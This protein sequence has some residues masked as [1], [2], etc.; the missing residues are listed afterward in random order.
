[1]HASF[2]GSVPAR[3]DRY[4]GPVLFEPYADDLVGRLEP[5]DD[6]RVLEVACGT[7]IVTRRLRQ[8]LPAGPAPPP[9]A[10]PP[11]HPPGPPP[12]PPGPGPRRGPPL[13]PPHDSGGAP[14]GGGFPPPPPA[15]PPAGGN[16]ARRRRPAVNPGFVPADGVVP[17]GHHPV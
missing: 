16:P 7:G 17:D 8:A 11:P 15:P 6:L 14:G 13:P 5:R 10:P 3:Y 1:T 9:P 12:P 4:L 2:S